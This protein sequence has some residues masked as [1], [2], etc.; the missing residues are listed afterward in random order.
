MAGAQTQNANS[1]TTNGGSIT[2]NDATNGKSYNIYRIFD[3]TLSGEATEN[4]TAADGTSTSKTTYSNYA[5]SITSDWVNFFVGDSAAGKEYLVEATAD[6]KTTYSGKDQLSY[7]GKTYYININDNNLVAFTKAALTYAAIL[8]YNDGQ[9]TANSTTVSFSNIKLGY[10]LV[11]PV[12]AAELKSGY[13]SICSLTT[14]NKD[15]S[16][17]IKADY[18]SI[19]K[20]ITGITRNDATA[21]QDGSVQIGDTVSYKIK[22]TVPDVTGYSSYTYKVSDTMSEGLTFGSNSTVTV[23]FGTGTASQISATTDASANPTLTI[24]NNGFVLEYDMVA[25]LNSNSTIKAGDP[26]TITYSATINSKAVDTTIN[27]EAKLVYSN[28][29][30]SNTT[31]TG[32]D[33]KKEVNVYSF[34]IDITK[35]VTDSDTK[36]G[37]AVFVLFKGTESDKKYLKQDATTKVITWVSDQSQATPFTTSS[38]TDKLGTVSIDGL[39]AGT[40]YLEETTAPA[41]YNKLANPITIVLTATKNTD[42]SLSTWSAKVD[43]TTVTDQNADSSLKTYLN[44]SAKTLT[45]GVENSTG[46]LLPSTGGMGTTIF[47]VAGGILVVGAMILLIARWRMKMEG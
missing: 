43:N 19:S 47:F 4:S 34:N 20:E 37:N 14:T 21:A 18:P 6:N 2:I 46:S 26:I 5:Y 13:S 30:T 23:Q 36:L 38:E 1:D 11:Y 12:G 41:G 3:L 28:D 31:N 8:T 24:A 10:Y 33:T 44:D 40:Y 25:Y 29:P 45:I 17:N 7:D 42:G 32:N 39:A 16:V 22:G 9:E 35:Y 27:N 15:A